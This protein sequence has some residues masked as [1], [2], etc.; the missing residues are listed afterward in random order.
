[1]NYVGFYVIIFNLISILSISE[2]VKMERYW[3]VGFLV[4]LK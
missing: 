2:K 1:M 4:F 3:S